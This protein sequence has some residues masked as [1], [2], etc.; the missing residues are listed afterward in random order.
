MEVGLK[1]IKLRK[2][3]PVI[4]LLAF[5]VLMWGCGD[6]GSSAPNAVISKNVVSLSPLSSGEYAVRGDNMEGAA[7]IQLSISYDNAALTSPTVT[8]GDLISGAMMAS[9]ISTPGMI[10]LAVI[11]TKAFSGNGQIATISFAA[12]TGSGNISITSV[13]MIDV[14]GAIIL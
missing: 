9:N 8:Q 7:G 11:S 6:G 3:A 14:K 1:Y 5:L 2:R 13:K 12:I 10:K 4:L